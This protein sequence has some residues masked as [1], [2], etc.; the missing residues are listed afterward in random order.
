MAPVTMEPVTMEPVSMVPERNGTACV[1]ITDSTGAALDSLLSSSSS[2]SL[3]LLSFLFVVNMSV[4]SGP[5][6]LLLVS[7]AASVS[8]PVLGWLVG[9]SWPADCLVPVSFLV[10]SSMASCFVSS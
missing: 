3:K 5:F 2:L 8:G 4:Y 1:G 7:G 10:S 6:C 9:Y